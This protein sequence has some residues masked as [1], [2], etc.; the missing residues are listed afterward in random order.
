MAELS[1]YTRVAWHL[2]DAMTALLVASDQL[3]VALATYS[4][5]DPGDRLLNALRR[6]RDEVAA[7][8]EACRMAYDDLRGRGE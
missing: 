8:D 2:R 4:G 1:R 6:T 3:T 7:A 5:T